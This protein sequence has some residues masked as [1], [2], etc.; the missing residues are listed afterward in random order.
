MTYHQL[1]LSTCTGRCLTSS[2]RRGSFK[3]QIFGQL[4]QVRF[5]H[6]IPSLSNLEGKLTLQHNGRP[7][8]RV[9]QGQVPS[10]IS[11]NITVN[12]PTF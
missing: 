11:S 8:Y 9:P 10:Q 6:Y 7:C 5:L 3:R 2:C 12:L 4:D 1:Y